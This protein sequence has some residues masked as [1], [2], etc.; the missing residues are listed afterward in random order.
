MMNVNVCIQLL[1]CIQFKQRMAVEKEEGLTIFTYLSQVVL[2][3]PFFSLL[4]NKRVYN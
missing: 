2:L 4:G 3:I 1:S